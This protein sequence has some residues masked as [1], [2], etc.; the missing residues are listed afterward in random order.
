[1]CEEHGREI[2][3]VALFGV[4]I[5]SV[6]F[7]DACAVID[8]RISRRV[9]GF[10]VTPNVDHICRLRKDAA[11]R[12]AYREAFLV[13]PDGMPIL[14]AARLA[15]TPLREKLSGSDLVPRLSEHAMRRGYSVY[16]L[17]AQPGVAA[18][19]ANR[20]QE[21]YPGLRV[22]G[23][24]S[25]PRNFGGDP[26]ANAEAVARLREAK[27]DICFVALG[28]P[29]QEIWIHRHCATAEVPVLVGVGAA[30]DFIAGRRKRAPVWMQRSG[31]EWVWRLCHEPRR[32]G[33][34][35]LIEDS[36]FVV[37]LL[38]EVIEKRWRKSRGGNT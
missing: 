30:F 14:W 29:K 6:T 4:G 7:E 26:E 10:I 37:L 1:L 18:L 11:L 22:A 2:D 31:L 8:E 35:Y 15:G 16:F 20:L 3:S 9:P 13:L 5:S 21:R 28:S 17:G 38:R 24:W 12:A 36:R 27:P 23:T 32:L 25:P 19:A 34:R 33:R